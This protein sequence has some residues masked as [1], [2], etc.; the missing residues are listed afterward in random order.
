[1]RVIF[2]SLIFAVSYDTCKSMRETDKYPFCIGFSHH[3]RAQPEV[4]GL[5]SD[6]LSINTTKVATEPEKSCTG[7]L[8]EN[9]RITLNYVRK[10][11]C[12]DYINRSCYNSIESFE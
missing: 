5:V 11:N 2:F 6:E 4:L 12:R 8:R 3:N 7:A 10:N 1:M 9:E